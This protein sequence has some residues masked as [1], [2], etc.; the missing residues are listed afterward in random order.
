[1]HPLSASDIVRIWERGQ[2]KPYLER[3]MLLLSAIFPE[4]ERDELASL[5]V[6]QRDAFLLALRE[7]TLGSQI[8]AY[9]RCPQCSENLEITI[10]IPDIQVMQPGDAKPPEYWWQEGD[11]QMRYRLLNSWDLATIRRIP[12]V[13][14]ARGQLLRL[15]VLEAQRQGVRVPP[16]DL[17]E[18]MVGV[19]TAQMEE[20]D[21]QADVRFNVSCPV[22]GSSW[23]TIFDIVSYLWT[24]VTVVAQRALMDVHELARAYGW[25]EMEILSMSAARRQLYLEMVG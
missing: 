24:E 19:L 20:Q 16:E 6:G 8:Q 17:P 18:E 13:V 9:A 7:K 1:M 23:Q 25:H 2:G 3:A 21:P 5:S 12:D 14:L 15:C 11:Y 10:N 22:C 4:T